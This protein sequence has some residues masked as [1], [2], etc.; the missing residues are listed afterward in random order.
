MLH[1]PHH[2]GCR[3]WGTGFMPVARSTSDCK[4]H[5]GGAGCLAGDGRGP[6]EPLTTLLRESGPRG[7]PPFSPRLPVNLLPAARGCSC[8][9]HAE[10]PR[11]RGERQWGGGNRAHW[12]PPGGAAKKHR[13]AG[14]RA[15]TS[16]HRSQ[17][18]PEQQQ[19]LHAEPQIHAAPRTARPMCRWEGEE[20]GHPRQRKA[21][22]AVGA[23]GC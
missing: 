14:G 5:S 8:A 6:V 10:L 20:A 22:A 11:R 15:L 4:G 23:C 16:T 3:V 12:L 13:P 7:L 17:G 19:R 1:A 2:E 9:A 21:Q 18:E